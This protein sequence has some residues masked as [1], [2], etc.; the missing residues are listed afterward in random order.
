MSVIVV[1]LRPLGL[2]LF[3]LYVVGYLAYISS[4]LVLTNNFLM[5]DLLFGAVICAIVS[6]VAGGVSARIDK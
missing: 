2:R 5:R 3:G 6:R 1:F 4:F